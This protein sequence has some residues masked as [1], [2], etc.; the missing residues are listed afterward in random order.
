MLVIYLTCKGLSSNVSMHSLR[1]N[2]NTNINFQSWFK[3]PI[4]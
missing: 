2:F 1:C 3:H 4:V